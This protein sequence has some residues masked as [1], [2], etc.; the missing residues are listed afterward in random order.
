MKY[1]ILILFIVLLIFLLRNK[2]NFEDKCSQY[3]MQSIFDLPCFS[4]SSIKMTMKYDTISK[5][6]ID[7][8]RKSVNSIMSRK[9]T[10]TCPAPVIPGIGGTTTSGKAK[11]VVQYGFNPNEVSKLDSSLVKNVHGTR[12]VSNVD[13]IPLLIALI[14]EFKM[15]KQSSI[16]T[17]NNLQTRV[18]DVENKI[19]EINNYINAQ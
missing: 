6:V 7:K 18:A 1:L 14:K 9:V 5:G 10:Y 15:T 11:S 3:E 4:D 16:D 8:F 12:F 13:M 2:E 19:T 17:S